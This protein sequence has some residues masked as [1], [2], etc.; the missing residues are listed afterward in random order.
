MR[1]RAQHPHARPP[2]GGS[3]VS[4]RHSPDVPRASISQRFTTK[5]SL[6]VQDLDQTT[7]LPSWVLA[8]LKAET[9][10]SWPGAVRG[11]HSLP[12]RRRPQF[13]RAQP[14]QARALKAWLPARCGLRTQGSP[15]FRRAQQTSH[16]SQAGRPAFWVQGHAGPRLCTGVGATE[17]APPSGGSTCGPAD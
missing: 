10:R 12:A 16:H 17:L 7:P 9:T 8:L 1:R 11:R 2:S 3:L 14:S 5:S 6:N 4:H 15:F 13:A